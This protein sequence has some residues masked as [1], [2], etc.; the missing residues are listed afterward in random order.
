MIEA[1]KACTPHS[2]REHIPQRTNHQEPPSDSDK[3]IAK[4][5]LLLDHRHKMKVIEATSADNKTVKFSNMM[6]DAPVKD[7]ET[8]KIEQ[9]GPF[10]FDPCP[11]MEQ[12]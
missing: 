2:H 6:A 11:E 10:T 1:L 9:M 12:N 3:F 4:E 5:N 7:S 8:S